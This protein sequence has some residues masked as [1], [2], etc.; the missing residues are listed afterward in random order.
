MIDGDIPT[1]K[2][3]SAKGPLAP[4]EDLDSGWPRA[5]KLH[6]TAEMFGLVRN[7]LLLAR[8]HFW[9]VPGMAVLAVL[10]SIF[11]GISLALIIPL[12]QLLDA[13]SGPAAGAGSLAFL[14]DLIELIP[15]Q[16][17]L[18]GI[19]IAIIAAVVIKSAINYANMTVLGIVYGRV[20][21]TLR[22]KIFSKIIN[23][24]LPDFERDR[25][26]RL[27]NILNVETWRATDALRFLFTIM[28][29]GATVVVLSC[30]LFYLS[31]RLSLVA[32]GCIALIAPIAQVI[33]ARA[34]A[35]S[36]Q[37]LTENE[38]LAKRT[39]TAL[40]G[41]RMIHAFG[42]EESEIERFRRSSNRVRSLFLRMA[43]HTMT[44]APVAEIVITV[45]IAMLFLFVQAGGMSLGAFAGFLAILYRLQ[46]RILSLASAH[47]NLLGLHAS[48]LAVSEVIQ[49][50]SDS[51]AQT[52]RVFTGLR[53]GLSFE[54]VTFTYKGSTDPALFDVSFRI[55]KGSVVAIVGTSGAGKST[56]IDLLLRFQQPQQG[57]IVVDD[58]A[59]NELNV[60]SWR[61]RLGVVNQDTYVFDDTVA[62]NLA[63]GSPNATEADI[64]DAARLACADDFIRALPDGYGTIVGERGTQLSGGQRQR[65]ALARALIRHPDILILDEATN[66]LDATT[67]RAFQLALSAYSKQRTV[68]I[69]AHRLVTIES[70]DH[71]I[72]LERGRVV[73]QG[74]PAALFKAGRAF[75]RNFGPQSAAALERSVGAKASAP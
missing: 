71:V 46:P 47:T 7:L 14:N 41:M 68:I 66:A 44:T 30:I 42:C 72:V 26:G 4:R 69:V 33:G 53:K 49:T 20:S 54:N 67:E 9:F 63:Y 70:A 28:M 37:G 65:L 15:V 2:P 24:P 5:G 12:V 40:N 73:E 34:K 27:L 17:T 61:A 59:L 25:S 31:W 13:G 57:R 56:L 21:H 50:P 45:V 36:K 6:Q 62:A 8:G 32:L 3:D 16:S 55:P 74:T 52:G 64:L 23:T 48:V 39:W 51:M 11:E 10:A 35:L 75:A 18:V 43:M 1:Q 29:S 19:V 22:T 38:V 60:A 58:T